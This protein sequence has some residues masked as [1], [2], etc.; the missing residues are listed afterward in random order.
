MKILNFGSLNIDMVYTVNHLAT[1]GETVR[2]VSR[3]MFCGGKGLNQ[4]VSMAKAGLSVFHAGLIGPDGQLLIDLLKSCGVDTRYIETVETASGHAV[5][6]VDQKGENNIIVYGGANQ[7]VTPAYIDRVL[8]YFGKGDVLLLQNEISNLSYI[9][10]RAHQKQMTIA[11]NPAPF[12][13]SLLELPM[14]E[15]D[16]LLVNEVEG[17]QF[18]GL[19]DP[20]QIARTLQTKYNTAVVLTLGKDGAI[21][22]DRDVFLF[23]PTYPAKVVDTTGAG[24]TFTGYFLY[25]FL[26][27][28]DPKLAM[29]LAAKASAIAVSR[30]GAAKS[31]PTKAEVENL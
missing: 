1:P 13:Q 17:A 29:E 24:D 26:T 9:I 8:S 6:Q 7:A 27:N 11:F 21:Y 15:I 12:E 22:A 28:G 4:S 20:N 5:I 10:N 25:G 18:S 23:Q 19:T 16:I 14:E 31:I 2:A 3:D 30:S